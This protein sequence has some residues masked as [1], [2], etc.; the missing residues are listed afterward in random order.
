MS[1]GLAVGV[2]VGGT[3][4]AAGLV[5]GDGT[6]VARDR[7]ETPADDP[8]AVLEAI[9]EVVGRICEDQ[10]LSQLPVGVGAAGLVDTDGVVLYAPNLAWR[11]EPLRARLD[12]RLEA[13]V[14]VANDA[15]VAAWGEFR[16]GAGRDVPGSSVMLTLGTGVGGGLIMGD[17]LLLGNWGVGGELG[18]IIIHEGGEP[19]P[20]GNRGCLEA[21]A[22]GTAIGRTAERRLAAGTVPS[23]SRLHDLDEITGK[24]V[25]LVAHRGDPAAVE[26]LAECGFWLGVGIASLVNALDPAVVIIGGGAMQAGDLLIGPARV[27]AAERI[28][29]RGLRPAAPIVR[30]TLGDDAGVIGAALLVLDSAAA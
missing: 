10:G 16:A 28:I 25:T 12:E 13:P 4:I 1:T 18:H 3:K 15:S 5:A 8:D 19:C 29:A 23:D 2:D 14:L 20:C 26:V 17:R 6:L 7:V 11:D 22:S 21:Y 9:A 24:S 27:S 30:A